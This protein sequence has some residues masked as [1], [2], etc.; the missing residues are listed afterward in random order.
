MA[1]EGIEKPSNTP[2]ESNDP[3]TGNDNKGQSSNAEKWEMELARFKE[4]KDERC[5]DKNTDRV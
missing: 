3:Q 4:W 2:E 1:T 5:K